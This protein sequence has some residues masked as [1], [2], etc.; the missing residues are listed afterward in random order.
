V[1]AGWISAVGDVAMETIPDARMVVESRTAVF[2]RHRMPSSRAG[3][4]EAEVVIGADHVR[5]EIGDLGSRRPA[6]PTVPARVAV[7]RSVGAAV[8]DA[9][10]IPARVL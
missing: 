3:P 1:L 9:G 8:Q 5:A 10:P 2:P 4:I 6:R 7:C